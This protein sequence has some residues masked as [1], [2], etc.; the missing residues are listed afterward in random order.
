MGGGGGGGGG[1]LYFVMFLFLAVLFPLF[2]VLVVYSIV[3][4][5]YMSCVLF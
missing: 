1:G 4:C 3:S 5:S 2:W